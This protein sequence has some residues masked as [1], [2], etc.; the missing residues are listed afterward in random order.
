MSSISLRLWSTLFTAMS[1]ILRMVSTVE[2]TITHILVKRI[3]GVCDTLFSL[4][5]N[6]PGPHVLC[7]SLS[8]CLAG[9]GTASTC[10][11]WTHASLLRVTRGLHPPNTHRKMVPLPC[12]PAGQRGFHSILPSTPFQSVLLS[13]FVG[14]SVPSSTS[15]P[16][17]K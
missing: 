3:E 16:G 9:G 11:P 1:P 5:C 10:S 12:E 7:S 17:A 15:T 2:N 8:A 13:S 6:F 14:N 4:D